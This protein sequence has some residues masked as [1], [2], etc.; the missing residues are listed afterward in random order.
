MPGS[1]R[2][3][4]VAC[5]LL[6]A[7]TPNI[8]AQG[9][10]GMSRPI[11][12]T[13][14]NVVPM[15]TEQVLTD[16]T[17][18][19]VDQEILA[20]GPSDEVEIPTGATLIDGAG[21]YLLPGLTDMHVHLSYPHDL[22]LLLVNGVTTVRM[23]WGSQRGLEWR[24]EINRRRRLGPTLFTSGP[25]LEGHPPAEYEEV[26]PISGKIL[27]ATADEARIEVAR[28][29]AA[30]YDFIKVYNNL[31]K[32]VYEA[33]VETAKV[34]GVPVVGHVAVDV[35]VEGAL[36]AGQQSIEHL[37][38]Y[39][40]L[41]VPTDAPIQP[42][43]DY[44][45]RELS[46]RYGDVSRAPAAAAAT[47][48]AGTYSTPTLMT[49]IYS[50]PQPYVD[51]FL[52]APEA[53]FMHPRLRSGLENRESM[54][55]LSFSGDDFEGSER[56][57]PVK[58]ALVRALRDSGAKILA[59][60]DL[61]PLG[62]TLHSELQ[63]LVE[64]GLTPYE[65]LEAATR[66]AAEA[67]GQSDVFGTIAQ[68]MRADL[69]LVRGNP[70]A[71]VAN[72]SRIEGVVVRGRWFSKEDLSERLEAVRASLPAVAALDRAVDLASR[73]EI[74]A[75]RDTIEHAL[76]LENTPEET[77]GYWS[78][79]CWYGAI[80]GHAN[81]VLSACDKAVAEAPE[82]GDAHDARGIARAL[83]GDVEGAVSDFTVF[84]EW[85]IKPDEVLKRMQWNAA[86]IQG[87]N[88]FTGQVLQSLR[89]EDCTSMVPAMKRCG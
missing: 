22:T 8:F 23:L 10:D 27:L 24:D 74:L 54:R 69:V 35:G 7:Q 72:A 33:I 88:P 57:Y 12:I 86:L 43:P 13:H 28:Q 51:R 80:W 83:T 73:G 75:A 30:G 65:A 84:I 26:I 4:I 14:V 87:E 21:L 64:A 25:I 78:S 56:G 61:T 76:R 3:V 62:F 31:P 48:D 6:P 81:D 34:Y 37:R 71:E 45:S 11:A 52:S 20:M 18:L 2:L 1:L 77:A 46:W 16:Q 68:G 50:M 42:G 89:E 63:N 58:Q 67:L 32:D 82:N 15:D 44:R 39:S 79:L 41:L 40:N 9:G 60:S 85:S 5:A 19:V 66:T 17:V 53:V 36:T 70:L 47:R 29:H 55:W 59:G 49:Q 38:G